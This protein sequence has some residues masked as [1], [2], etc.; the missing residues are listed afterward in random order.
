MLIFLAAKGGMNA[1]NLAHYHISEANF[2]RFNRFVAIYKRDN[3]SGRNL[4][5]EFGKTYWYYFYFAVKNEKE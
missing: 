1:E 5:D 4:T 2:Q 3:G